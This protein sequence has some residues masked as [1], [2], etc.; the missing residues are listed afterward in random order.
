MV[1]LILVWVNMFM[2]VLAAAPDDAE[3]KITGVR[4]S[5]TMDAATGLVR[6]RLTVETSRAAR[7]KRC[8]R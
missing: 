3:T 5:R 4:W 2:G 6:V 1:L 7:A 8:P